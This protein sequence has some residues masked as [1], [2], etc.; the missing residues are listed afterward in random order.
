[1]NLPDG[2]KLV[3]LTELVNVVGPAEIDPRTRNK[4]GELTYPKD[5][6][7]FA[8]TKFKFAESKME[9]RGAHG[10]KVKWIYWYWEPNRHTMA[11]FS[12]IV[13]K[14]SRGRFIYIREVKS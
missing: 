4:K 1:M 8:S 9:K 10:P 11:N 6:I 5:A 2:W 7:D 12:G 13:L 14:A 3:K